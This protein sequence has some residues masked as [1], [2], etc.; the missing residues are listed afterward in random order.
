MKFNKLLY[1][2]RPLNTVH[3]LSKA[4]IFELKLSGWSHTGIS[5]CSFFSK[6]KSK[7]SLKIIQDTSRNSS[8]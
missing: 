5:F 8:F 2:A 3:C 6:F 7:I 4:E 1:V